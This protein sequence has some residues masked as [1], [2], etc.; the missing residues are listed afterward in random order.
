MKDPAAVN[1]QAGQWNF[2]VSYMYER[3]KYLL[4]VD[5]RLKSYISRGQAR[6]QNISVLAVDSQLS[7]VVLSCAH[8][9][10]TLAQQTAL[11]EV[12]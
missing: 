9:S 11:S 5:L 12:L 2:M 1:G 10:T 6:A 7:S 3:R 8:I 4:V